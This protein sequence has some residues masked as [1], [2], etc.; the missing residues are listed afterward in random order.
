MTP[1]VVIQLLGLVYG[2]KIKTGAGLSTAEALSKWKAGEIIV[3][4]EDY[5][6]G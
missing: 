5:I 6:Y 1:L 3:F 4:D 2:H